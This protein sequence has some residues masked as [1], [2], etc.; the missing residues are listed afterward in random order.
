M[1][2]LKTAEPETAIAQVLARVPEALTAREMA[3]DMAST[4][5]TAL[6]TTTPLLSGS[7]AKW[8]IRYP[9]PWLDNC[10]NRTLVEPISSPI[11]GSVFFANSFKTP[12]FLSFVNGLV[13]LLI[14]VFNRKLCNTQIPFGIQLQNDLLADGQLLEKQRET[15]GTVTY[16]HSSITGY[17]P[18]RCG[19]SYSVPSP[20][21]RRRIYQLKFHVRC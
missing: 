15:T 12:P 3:F 11:T 7:I 5:C 9:D 17:F 14:A 19:V 4:S 21:I 10:S 20:A 13:R 8:S 2:L 1:V 16:Q 6:S 18:V